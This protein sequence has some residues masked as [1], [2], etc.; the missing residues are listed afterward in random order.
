MPVVTRRKLSTILIAALFPAAFAI[1]VPVLL[2]FSAERGQWRFVLGAIACLSVSAF[3]VSDVTERVAVDDTEIRVKR[4]PFG[5]YVIGAASV[6]RIE[7]FTLDRWLVHISGRRRPLVLTLVLLENRS[8]V[9]EA[10]EG[11]AGRNRIGIECSDIYRELTD[12]GGCSESFG[13]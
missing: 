7:K 13:N 1:A 2:F 4:P 6:E 3:L 12:G 9:V 8:E 5:D 10:V 11:F